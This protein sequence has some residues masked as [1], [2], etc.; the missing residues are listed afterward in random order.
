MSG[1]RSSRTLPLAAAVTLAVLAGGAPAALAHTHPTP[2]ERAAPAVVY[3]EARAK[4]EVALIEHRTSPDAAG[5]HIGVAQSTWN[6]VLDAASGFVVDP[7]GAIVTSGAVAAPDLERAKIYAVNHAF[8]KQYGRAALTE[9]PFTKHHIGAASDRNE[10]RLQACYPPHQINDAGG[11]IVRTTLDMVVYPYVSSQQRY[12]NLRAEVLSASRDVATLRVRGANGWPTVRVAQ[13]VAG[14]SALGVLGFTGVPSAKYPLIEINQHLA[15]PG[16][17]ELRTAN[18]DAQDVKDAAALKQALGQGF[19]GGPVVAESGQVVGL[20]TGPPRAGT[21][22]PDLV[23]VASILAV[24]K[25]A[26]VSPQNGPVDTS[27]ERAMHAFKNG[28][29]AEAIPYFNQ[30]LSVFPGHLRARANL[31][32]AEERVKSG[33]GKAAPVPGQSDDQGASAGGFPWLLVA[34][35]GLAALMLGAVVLALV[36]RSRSAE[37]DAAGPSAP[38]A[39]VPVGAAHA[40]SPGAAAARAGPAARGGPA[41]PGT[42]RPGPAPGPSGHRPSA[43]AAGSASPGAPSQAAGRASGQPA[44]SGRPSASTAGPGA[45]RVAP[46]GAAPQ[47]GPA[48]QGGRQ[49]VP[50]PGT[51]PRPSAQASRPVA[52]GPQAS[53]VQQASAAT[54]S[55][56]GFRFCTA[57]GGRLAAQHQFCGWCGEPVS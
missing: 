23:G 13:S 42:A 31:A 36:R 5:V 48:P 17:A 34:G 30:A 53:S 49:A 19:A 52:R 41:R 40:V 12:G 3:V 47:G 39:P 14:A 25:K 54:A 28:G 7:N 43:G 26:G 57:C 44:A 2:I 20:L 45:A 16:A 27:Y 18:L 22:A 50:A 15:K 8:A 46:L 24:L 11:C 1:H 35:A 29:Y 10:Q 55:T 37:A 56:A 6:P 51:Q 9:D 32:I 38:R 21:P 33:G 4:V